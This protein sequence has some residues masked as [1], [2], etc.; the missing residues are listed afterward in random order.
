M[1]LSALSTL[2]VRT[3][4]PA[5][6]ILLERLARSASKFFGLSLEAKVSLYL[7]APSVNA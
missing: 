3:L 7:A 4:R 6:R 1:D 2:V 5:V